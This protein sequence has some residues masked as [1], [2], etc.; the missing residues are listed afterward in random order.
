MKKCCK[1]LGEHAM[2]IVSFKRKKMKLLSNER[3]ESYENTN[4][5][6][7]CKEMFEDI[8]TKD[9]KYCEVR[10][11]CHYTGEYRYVACSICNLK[12]S[13]PNEIT[14]IFHNESRYDDHFIIKELAEEFLGLFTCL[15]ENTGKYII[16]LI[17]KEKSYKN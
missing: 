16:F 5:C 12:H 10:D 14:I 2:Q 3:Q 11:H 15:D 4:I 8:Y 13:I 7:I 6:C 9:K 17:P 1:S